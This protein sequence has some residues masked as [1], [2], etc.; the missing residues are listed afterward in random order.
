MTVVLSLSLLFAVLGSVSLALTVA[1]FVIVPPA[2]GT[3]WIVIVADPPLESEPSVQETVPAENE[4]L[5]WL[6]VAETKVTPLG[7]VSVT[8]TFVAVDG[9]ALVTVRV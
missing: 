7:R 4:Q 9:P 1:V 3:T 2:F 5:P 6:A 8:V